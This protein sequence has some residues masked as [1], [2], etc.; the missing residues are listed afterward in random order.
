MGLNEDDD[1]MRIFM[2]GWN[3]WN[4]YLI[5]VGSYIKYC[6]SFEEVIGM[7]DVG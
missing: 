3:G 7:G 6:L 1:R 5:E 4:L 2:L